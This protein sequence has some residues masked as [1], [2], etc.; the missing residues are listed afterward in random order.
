MLQ[1]PG[2]GKTG[3]RFAA[4]DQPDILALRRLPGLGRDGLG[5][6]AYEGDIQIGGDWPIP[7]AHD[8]GGDIL[9]GPVIGSVRHD[10]VIGLRPHDHRSDRLIK[11]IIGRCVIPQRK[12]LQP[13][14]FVLLSG[15]ITIQGGSYVIDQR[16]HVFSL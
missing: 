13:I 11:I 5:I 16:R 3:C 7:V 1:F 8:K 2:V 15:N 14:E 6:T 4:T 12:V 9:V 10:P